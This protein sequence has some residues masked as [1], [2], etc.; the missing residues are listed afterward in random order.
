MLNYIMVINEKN[1]ERS[2]RVLMEVVF[3]NLSG[4]ARPMYQPRTFR[5]QK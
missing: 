2:F 3:R 5:T 1:L 4:E